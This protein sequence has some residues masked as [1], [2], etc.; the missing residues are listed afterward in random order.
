MGNIQGF[1]PLISLPL[2]Q[3]GN[4]NTMPQTQRAEGLSFRLRSGQCEDH[5]PQGAAYGFC[6]VTSQP[7]G[8]D[9]AHRLADMSHAQVCTYTH[10][11][12]L[13][14]LPGP[15]WHNREAE[16]M[17]WRGP[18]AEAGGEGLPPSTLQPPKHP[19][20]RQGSRRAVTQL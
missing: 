15:R 14:S 13:T 18:E 11:I 7:G 3:D 20:E 1:P 17:H 5:Q 19:A 2:C 16:A 12:Y 4:L 8:Q 10:N 6:L 9:R